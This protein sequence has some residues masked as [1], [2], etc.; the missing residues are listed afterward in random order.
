[1]P[2]RPQMPDGPRVCLFGASD[3]V[4]GSEAYETARAVGHRLAERGY[5]VV[6]GGYGGTM[7]ASAR[8]AVEAGGSA[9]GVTCALWRS[10]PNAYVRPVIETPGLPQRLATLLEL[11]TAGAVVLPGSTGTLLE[12]AAVWEEVAHG[13]I[14][15]RPIVCLG[16]FWMPLIEMMVSAHPSRGEFIR[17]VDGPVELAGCFPPTAG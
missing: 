16:A 12:L 15:P 2:E 11:G 8:G 3:P 4:E 10:R 14:A 13:A 7:E 1:M 9:I 17:Q 5:V 6:N